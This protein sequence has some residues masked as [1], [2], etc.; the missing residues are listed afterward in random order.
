V[1]LEQ[2]TL[3]V[4]VLEV[5]RKQLGTRIAQARRLAEAVYAERRKAGV[6][7]LAP[8]LPGG[9]EAGTVAIKAGTTDV[10]F[11]D[12]AVLEFVRD[13]DPA[14]VES[15]VDPSALVDKR[16]ID[17]ITEHLPEFVSDRVTPAKR[18]ELREQLA[19]AKNG[20]LLNTATG[21]VVTVAY[22]A[23]NEPTGDFAYTPGKK[24]MAAV[25]KALED[26]TV[27]EDGEIAGAAPGTAPAEPETV[28]EAEALRDIAENFLA[29][30]HGFKNPEFAAAH[31]THV[32]GGWS[33]PPI[34]AYRMLRDGGVPA[35]RART[36]LQENGLDP[37]DPREGRGTPWPLPKPEGAAS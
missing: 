16:V 7:N 9:I 35:E 8:V 22:V 11:Y 26:G 36:W 6:K 17:L 31:A 3:K 20:E 13:T 15:Y 24:G 33:T 14:S 29:D 30:E 34:E 28:T 10:V 4:A 25:L 19:E 5:R 1:N 27:T 2:I 12:G 18:A 21:E 32:Q 23:V 37:E